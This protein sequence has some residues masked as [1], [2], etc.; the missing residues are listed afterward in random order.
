M[1]ATL[2]AACAICATIAAVMASAGASAPRSGTQEQRGVTAPANLATGVHRRASIRDARQLLAGVLTP[3]GAVVSSSS[4]GVGPHASL[5][6]GA[7]DSAV[8]RRS[9][10]V[11]EDASAVLSFVTKH[12]PPGS[13]VQSTGDGGSPPSQ[14]VIRTWPPVAGVLGGRWLQLQVTSLKSGRT[15][16]SA[17]AQSQWIVARS[18]SERIPVGVRQIDVTSG[19]PGER[20]FLFRR[21]TEGQR[22]QA[23]IRLFDARPLVQ[24][25]AINCPGE[26]VNQAVVTVTFQRGATSRPVASARVS[27][28]ANFGWPAITAGWACVPVSLDI[29]GRRRPALAGNVIGPMQRILGVKLAAHSRG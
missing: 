11:G 8:A 25:V 20:P 17:V 22:V 9:W 23:L 19:V 5:L 13:K 2:A 1:V 29:L 12:L 28:T 15:L 4:T 24:P 18:A 14:S 21:V 7:L 26:S 16:L 27:P 6:T 10:T 3:P